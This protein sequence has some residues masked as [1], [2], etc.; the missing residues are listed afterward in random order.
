LQRYAILLRLQAATYILVSGVRRREACFAKTSG[1]PRVR[2]G[3]KFNPHNFN[4][5]NK[6][7]G[8]KPAFLF[9]W[10]RRRE[11]LQRY[12]ILLRLQA[13]TYIL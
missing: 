8:I 5:I 12:A 13:A 1:S 9:I 3:R 4:Q 2:T 6:K 10:W 7:A 11:S